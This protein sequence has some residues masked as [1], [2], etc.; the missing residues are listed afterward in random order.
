MFGPICDDLIHEG[1]CFDG[2]SFDNIDDDASDNPLQL[3]QV[4]Q[5]IDNPA[6]DGS[7]EGVSHH[8]HVLFRETL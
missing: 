5:S 6:G 7:S 2:S 4:G 8:H 1:E 3:F